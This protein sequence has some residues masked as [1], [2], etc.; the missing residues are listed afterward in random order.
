MSTTNVPRGIIP[1]MCG[2]LGNQLFIM[3]SSYVVSQLLN[4]PL[5]IF[6]NTLSNNKHNLS[7]LDYNKS[8]FKYFGVIFEIDYIHISKIEY[9]KDYVYH[10]HGMD[11]PYDHWNP[12]D[13]KVGTM[14][15][16][17]YQYYPAIM[18]YETQIRE[19]IL[20][21]LS[22]YQKIVQEYVEN[23]STVFVHIR[24]GDFV[25]LSD[26]HYLQPESYYCDCIQE[27]I[28]EKK[29]AKEINI[30]IVSDNIS[31]VRN[32]TIFNQH[33]SKI[34]NE[35]KEVSIGY[36]MNLNELETMALMSLCKGGAVCS[37]STF[38]WWGAFLGAH[39]KRNT[40]FVPKKWI[41]IKDDMS[42]LFPK[43]WIQV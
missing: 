27:L 24:R 2:G 9:F 26:I 36:A 39:E 30:L 21:G 28:K 10:S 29:G 11:K 4:C 25:E 32:N 13:V 1:I 33:F 7:K 40:V 15:S 14:M 35:H 43:E 18:N 42:D 23:E 20:K 12:N 31:W 38:S 3:A 22:D 41:N 5:F 17:Y 16:S 8:I 34:Y 6:T 19:I 37:N